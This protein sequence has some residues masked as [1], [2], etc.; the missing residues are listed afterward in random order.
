VLAL[1]QPFRGLRDG[2]DGCGLQ[3]TLATW[4]RL[5]GRCRRMV[6]YA[7]D[8]LAARGFIRRHRRYVARAWSEWR[9]DKKTRELELVEHQ[10][11]DIPYAVY[12]TRYGARRLE[13]RG[14]TRQLTV[15]AG[16]GRVRVLRA[17]GLVGNLLATLGQILKTLALRLSEPAETLHPSRY[18][19]GSSRSPIVSAAPPFGRKS[20]SGPHG[21]APPTTAQPVPDSALHGHLGGE[22]HRRA[23]QAWREQL[24]ELWRRGAGSA[25]AAWPDLWSIAG[26]DYRRQLVEQFEPYRRAITRRIQEGYAR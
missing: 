8:E 5:L 17:T 21:P 6:Q 10:T 26:D 11:V 4:S 19:T 1:L 22:G 15:I 3:L 9:R 13:R 23:A 14:E 12:L 20:V 24:D 2:V 7:F 18:S 25:A 16:Q